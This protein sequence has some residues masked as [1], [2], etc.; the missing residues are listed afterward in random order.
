M[1]IHHR[2]VSLA[3]TILLALTAA[4]CATAETAPS[5]TVTTVNPAVTR[6][7]KLEWTPT[8]AVGSNAQALDCWVVNNY[9]EP[10]RI[11][12]LAQAL[13]AS[14]QVVDQKID[15]PIATIGGYSRSYYYI[16]PLA[17]AD[18]YRVTVWSA[19]FFGSGGRKNP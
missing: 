5:A 10:A 1:R 14:G 17:A 3:P 2:L 4:A 19:Y 9:G 16:G 11:E 12:L 6:Y 7:F 8:Q 15:Y 18:H 13:D